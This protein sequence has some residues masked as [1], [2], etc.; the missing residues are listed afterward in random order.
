[1]LE[2]DSTWLIHYKHTDGSGSLGGPHA[3]QGKTTRVYLERGKQNKMCAFVNM[4][5][6]ISCSGYTIIHTEVTPGFRKELTYDFHRTLDDVWQLFCYVYG[7]LD[8]VHIVSDF[9]L[10]NVYQM[11]QMRA[12]PDC[13]GSLKNSHWHWQFEG[14]LILYIKALKYVGLSDLLWTNA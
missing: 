6:T 4:W 5:M 10:V 1:L 11:T 9:R 8:H 14:P 13:L 3:K 2:V 12:K 7:A